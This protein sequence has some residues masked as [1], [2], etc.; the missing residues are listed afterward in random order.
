MK[1]AAGPFGPA[2]FFP[3]LFEN[4]LQLCGCGG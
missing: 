2:A 1:K 4:L 3:A